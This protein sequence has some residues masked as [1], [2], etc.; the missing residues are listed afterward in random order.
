MLDCIKEKCINI[1][2]NILS[3]NIGYTKYKELC[4]EIANTLYKSNVNIDSYEMLE[5]ILL[6]YV[7]KNDYVNLN[8]QNNKV[9]IMSEIAEKPHK[10]SKKEEVSDSEE[11]KNYFPGNNFEL[12]DIRINNCFADAKKTKLNENKPKWIDY[13][14]NSASKNLKGLLMDTNVVLA[15]DEIL[16]IST[17]LDENAQLINE[18]LQLISEEYKKMH[19]V[20]YKFIAV[21]KE[22][23]TNKTEEYKDNLKKGKKYTKVAEPAGTGD[24]QI[25]DD[26]FSINKV[27]IK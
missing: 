9:N 19:D 25:L 21:N 10:S 17:E 6:D 18:K 16:V 5:L 2:K 27:E 14:N 7:N 11:N 23:W 15:S 20:D 3:S 4:F 12:V 1:K 24:S 22:Y 13:I 8:V 26:V